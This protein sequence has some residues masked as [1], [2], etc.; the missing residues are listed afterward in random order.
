MDTVFFPTPGDFRAWLLQHHE[1]EGELWVGFY[2]KATGKPSITWPE[3]VDEALCVG[4]IDGKRKRLD[5]ESYAIRFTPRREGSKWSAVNIRKMERLLEADRV[6]PAGIAAW[7]ARPEQASGYS[8]E[9]RDSARLDDAYRDEFEADETAWAYFQAQAPW[10]RR[11]AVH[12]VM[13]AKR[14]ETRRRRLGILIDSSR[15]GEPVPPLKRS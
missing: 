4:W 1:T 7:R 2:K 10:Y 6:L 5:E 8:Y 9:E 14:E 12:W 15:A 3:S 11:T 13:S